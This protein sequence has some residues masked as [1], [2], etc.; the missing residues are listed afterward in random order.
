[1]STDAVTIFDYLNYRD[2]ITAYIAHKKTENALFSMRAFAAKIACNPGFFNRII[3]G[4]R[5]L[6]P[7]LIVEIGKVLKFTKKEHRYFETL[8]SYNDAKKQMERDH[9]FEQLQSF[10]KTHATPVHADQYPLYSHWYYLVIRELLSLLPPLASPDA[11]AREISKRLTPQVSSG[12]IRDALDSLIRCG[13]INR[14]SDG[15]LSVSDTFTASGA[16]VPQVIVNRFL[17]ECTDLARRAVDVIPKKERRLSTVT[18]SCS[19]EGFEKI[20][21]RIDEFR[22]ELLA[23]I[24]QDS[25]PLD[26]VCHLNLHLFPVTDLQKGSV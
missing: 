9:H 16:A 4:E 12:E 22:Q 7:A 11:Y 6:T 10:R 8:V 1:M 3:K 5:S 23:V 26:R 21:S 25:A 2:F 13:I 14:H 20:S 24:S 15:R 19:Q 17:L 18:F